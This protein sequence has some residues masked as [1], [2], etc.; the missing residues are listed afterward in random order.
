MVIGSPGV[1]I[2]TIRFGKVYSEETVPVSKLYTPGPG[3]P[4]YNVPSTIAV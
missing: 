3:I 2:V 1:R 4:G